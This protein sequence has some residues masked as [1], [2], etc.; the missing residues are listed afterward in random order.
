MKIYDCFT[1][2][3]EA[4]IVEIRFEE[5]KD[6]VDYF[7]I[8]EASQTFTGEDKP[9]YFDE[10]EDK[11]SDIKE[12]IIRV[13]YSFSSPELSSWE[14]EYE[15]RNAIILGLESAGPYDVIII[16]DADEIPRSTVTEILP[17]IGLPIHLEV[18]QYFWNFNW[19]VPEHCNQ[20]A[21]PAVCFKFQLQ[22][23]TPQ[24]MRAKEMA[25]IKGAGWHFS[26]FGEEQK[27]KNKIESFAHTE[28]DK[29]EYKSY[30]NIKYRIENGIDPFDR[31]PLKYYNIDESYPKWV[32]DKY[33]KKK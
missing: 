13:K 23:S 20:G 17:Y 25:R 18:K 26:F 22:E 9:F 24:E 14:R 11:F 19:Q 8:V 12:K 33:M 6:Y 29:D 21:R 5:L 16:S 28:Y 30:E 15:Q 4:E 7:V 1:Y 3:N 27:V 32:V 2:H 10:I 31:F